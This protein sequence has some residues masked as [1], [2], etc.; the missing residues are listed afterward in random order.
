[1]AS[2][3]NNVKRNLEEEVE[4]LAARKRL[5]LSDVDGSDDDSSDLP[6]EDT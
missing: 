2:N 5:R 6:K 3:D 1:M 4:S